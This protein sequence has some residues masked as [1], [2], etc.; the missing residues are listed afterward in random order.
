MLGKKKSA[1]PGELEG[2]NPKKKN[3]IS[4]M[5]ICSAKN[6]G[7]DLLSREKLTV[8]CEAIFAIFSGD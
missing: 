7:G 3:K 5:K 1:K 2:Q 4:R 8:Q 6:E